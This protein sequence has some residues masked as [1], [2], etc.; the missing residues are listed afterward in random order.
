MVYRKAY[1]YIICKDI[2]KPI[3]AKHIYNIHINLFL[4]I[5]LDGTALAV[6]ANEEDPTTLQYN[7]FHIANRK[8]N[9]ET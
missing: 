4:E 5:K 9:I 6:P 8:Y 1:I 3:Q 2:Y 7:R